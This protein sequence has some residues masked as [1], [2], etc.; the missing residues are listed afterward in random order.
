MAASTEAHR[1]A[2]AGTLNGYGSTSERDRQRRLDHAALYQ[3][4]T[5]AARRN[6][7]T[8]EKAQAELARRR[9]EIEERMQDW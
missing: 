8:V 2:M 1:R 5:E 3:E 4:Q 7:K 6:L 9:E